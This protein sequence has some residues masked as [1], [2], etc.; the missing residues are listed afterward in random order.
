MLILFAIQA[1]L[2]H[3]LALLFL[4]LHPIWPK[5]RGVFMCHGSSPYAAATKL[6]EAI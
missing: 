6:P 5:A 4:L 2:R 1:V 3:P